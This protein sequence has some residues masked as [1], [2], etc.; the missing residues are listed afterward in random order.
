MGLIFDKDDVNMIT[1]DVMKRVFAQKHQNNDQQHQMEQ[2]E[3]HQQ[4]HVSRMK[5]RVAMLERELGLKNG[6][7]HDLREKVDELELSKTK[8]AEN[9]NLCLNQMRGYLLQYQR[10][11]IN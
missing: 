5:D 9:A 8:L 2:M 1:K 7:L 3:A 11:V 4:S 6:Q 10:T